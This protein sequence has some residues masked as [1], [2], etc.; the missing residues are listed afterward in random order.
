MRVLRTTSTSVLLLATKGV[1]VPFSKPLWMHRTG[2][3]TVGRAVLVVLAVCVALAVRVWVPLAVPVSVDVCDWLGVLVDVDVAD[4]E[5]VTDAVGDVVGVME[6]VDVALFVRELVPVVVAVLVTVAVGEPETDGL[7]VALTVAVGVAVAVADS[8]VETVDE[9]VALAVSEAVAEELM[10]EVG[11]RVGV[12]LAMKQKRTLPSNSDDGAYMSA[13]FCKE[14]VTVCDDEGVSEKLK[15]CH[16][17]ARKLPTFNSSRVTS[18][19]EMNLLST[20]ATTAWSLKW[21]AFSMTSP[22]TKRSCR[23]NWIRTDGSE[24]NVVDSV[25]NSPSRFEPATMRAM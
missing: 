16:A 13:K 14:K 3:S 2:P 21:V 7:L 15:D 18:V 17:V 20:A 24:T 11:V 19:R 1:S 22:L 10:V 5:L 23:C 9:G 4:S 6:L 25:V 12:E 8:L